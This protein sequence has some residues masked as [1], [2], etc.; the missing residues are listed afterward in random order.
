MPLTH[1]AE[2]PPALTEAQVPH[3]GHT[4]KGASHGFHNDTTPP[5]DDSNVINNCLARHLDSNICRRRPSGRVY[6]TIVRCRRH[7][8]PALGSDGRPLNLGTRRSIQ[9]A[10]YR[11]FIATSSL[12]NG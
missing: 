1:A 11:S 7:G 9:Q 5:Y 8:R 12:G 4:Y 3:E 6:N 10:A 2:D